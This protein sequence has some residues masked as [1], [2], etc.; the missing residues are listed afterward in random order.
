M[1]GKDLSAFAKVLDWVAIFD[2]DICGPW[3]SAVCANSPLDD[4]CETPDFRFGSATSGVKAWTE[5]GIPANKLVL[6]V[7]AYGHSFRVRK[8]DA[9]V[10]GTNTLASHPP[11]DHNDI[12]VGDTWDDAAGNDECD[13]PQ[14]A[15]GNINLWALIR[16]GYL[17]KTGDFANSVPHS[18]DQCSQTVSVTVSL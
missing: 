1:P 2:Y 8:A 6:G 7:P 17:T 4:T 9:F 10:N 18:F 13:V 12:P 15:G 5:A 16:E 11:F 3:S 14:K